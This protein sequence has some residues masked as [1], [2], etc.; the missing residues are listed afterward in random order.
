MEKRWKAYM[1]YSLTLLV[2]LLSIN[3]VYGDQDDQ[4]IPHNE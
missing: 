2:F 4:D 3:I 1:K